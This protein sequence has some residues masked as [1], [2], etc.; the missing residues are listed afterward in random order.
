MP[1]EPRHADQRRRNA[2]TAR[3]EQARRIRDRYRRRGGQATKHTHDENHFDWDQ[4]IASLRAYF[5]LRP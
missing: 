1:D 4:A 5:R 2:S 3:A